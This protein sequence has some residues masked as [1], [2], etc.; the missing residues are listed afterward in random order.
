MG[1]EFDWV[2]GYFEESFE[3]DVGG[4]LV[5]GGFLFGLGGCER[6]GDDFVDEG[7]DLLVRE[8]GFLI[9][10]EEGEFLEAAALRADPLGLVE[11]VGEGVFG[12]VQ[13]VESAKL[14]LDAFTEEQFCGGVDGQAEEDGLDVSCGGP[15]VG[16]DG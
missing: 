5:R 6:V 2:A 12:S 3:E 1:A 13:V 8:L 14:A 9:L 16:C 10:G 15:S 4:L 11:V 7:V